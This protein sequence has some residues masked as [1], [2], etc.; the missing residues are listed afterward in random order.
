MSALVTHLRQI[1]E[2]ADVAVLPQPPRP[3]FF[4]FT[5]STYG[6][7]HVSRCHKIA[8]DFVTRAPFDAHVISSHPDFQTGEENPRIHEVGLPPFVFGG[9]EPPSD[10]P[11]SLP[12]TPAD[13]VETDLL[14][15]K[16]RLLLALVGRLAPRG[17]LIDH[18]PFPPQKASAE[19]EDTLAYL[20]R[21]SPAT[22][23]CA[24]FRG[25]MPRPYGREDQ[26]FIEQPLGDYV[27]LFFIYMD[28]SER[29]DF[30][31]A[32]PFL[33]SLE[34]RM[35]FVGYVCPPRTSL[36]AQP[37]TMLATFGGGVD[38]YRKI[39]LVCEAFLTFADR[40]PGYAFQVVTGTRLPDGGY[41]EI[42]RRYDGRS[43]IRVTAFL[44]GLAARLGSFELVL[45]MGGY[46]ALT[47]LYQSSTCSVVLPRISPHHNE[48]L[49]Q[50]QKFRRHG[51]VGPVVDAA[52]TTPEALARVMEETLSAPR[53]VQRPLTDQG[54]RIVADLLRN[55]LSRREPSIA[56]ANRPAAGGTP[57]ATL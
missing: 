21:D 7:G 34:T 35:R 47:E 1:N 6:Y 20:R 46:N 52:T 9:S 2:V 44:P 55:E 17:I 23:R 56:V 25:V 43:G 3:T 51:V 49:I 30:L 39:H 33:G 13:V 45:T 57:V 37:G 24:G 38:A 10:Y 18:F 53:S 22:L 28:E 41:Q 11:C 50:A 26:R 29:N 48:Q 15:H 54:S 32:Y 27:D 5:F 8:R 16:S 12:G 4:F 31:A 36:A 40:H 42:V 19:C 14:H